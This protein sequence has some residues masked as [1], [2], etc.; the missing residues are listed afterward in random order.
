M[1]LAFYKAKHGNFIDAIVSFFIRSKY[2][3]VEI[4]FSDGLCASASPR[5][6]GVRFK[7]INLDNGKWDLYDINE[8]VL[9]EKEVKIWFF[10]HLGESYDT[11]GAIGSGIGIPLYSKHKKFCSLCLAILFDLDNINLNPETL[12]KTLLKKGHITKS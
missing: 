8:N 11:L 3:H 1:K 12:R 7:R 5:E 4:V 2:S 10:R 6:K 9:D